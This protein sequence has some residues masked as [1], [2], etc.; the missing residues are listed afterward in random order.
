MSKLKQNESIEKVMTEKLVTITRQTK[1]SEVGA[2]FAEGGFHHLPVVSGNRLEGIVSYVDY[3]RICFG[4]AFNQDDREVAAMLD[5]SKSVS[6]I[7]TEEVRTIR[8][9]DSVKDATKVLAES[10]FHSLP[11][12][13]ENQELVG[14]VTSSDLLEYF[15]ESY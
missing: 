1:I 4:D 13:G 8:K 7:M 6:D 3:M 11:V 15:Y 10:H 5:H 14:L 12:V 9:I 2:L